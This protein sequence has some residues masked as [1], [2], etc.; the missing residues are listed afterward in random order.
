MDLAS[1]A[2]TSKQMMNQQSSSTT[3]RSFVIQLSAM[4]AEKPDFQL[5]FFVIVPFF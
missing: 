5:F 2:I 4:M 3:T 1:C